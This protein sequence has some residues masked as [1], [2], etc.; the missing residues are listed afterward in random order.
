MNPKPLANYKEGEKVYYL[1]S[2]KTS[3]P[4]W[5]NGS[6]NAKVFD[7]NAKTPKVVLRLL[8]YKNKNSATKTNT[9]KFV[10]IKDPNYITPLLKGLHNGGTR[11][12]CKSRRRSHKTRRGTRDSRRH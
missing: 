5:Q 10:T 11:R 9:D 7:V 12:N 6:Q 3:G 2:G 1:P 8:N 4:G